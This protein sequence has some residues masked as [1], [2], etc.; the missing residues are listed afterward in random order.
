M[1]NQ[2]ANNCSK[3]KSKVQQNC[4]KFILIINFQTK[5][6]MLY[7]E[8]YN[9]MDDNRSKNIFQRNE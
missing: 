8:S 6:I 3:Q 2:L 4:P 9:L 5:L 1:I 7:M